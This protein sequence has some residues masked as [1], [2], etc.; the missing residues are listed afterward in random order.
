MYISI[1][2]IK[3]KNPFRGIIEEEPTITG[4]HIII[5]GITTKIFGIRV[6]GEEYAPFGTDRIQLC[7]L[8]NLKT[9]EIINLNY[10]ILAGHWKPGLTETNPEIIEVIKRIITDAL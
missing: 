1:C 10:A 6:I 7:H 2:N 4:D 9:D 5:N 3:R 8:Y